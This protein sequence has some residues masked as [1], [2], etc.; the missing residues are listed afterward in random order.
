L[1]EFN[2]A[3]PLLGQTLA[4]WRHRKDQAELNSRLW[5]GVLERDF[6]VQRAKSMSD[7]DGP[8]AISLDVKTDADGNIG[9]NMKELRRRIGAAYTWERLFTLL[10]AV[11]ALERYMLASTTA[12]IESDPLLTPGFPK[13]LDGLLLKKMDLRISQPSLT[14][15]VKGEWAG[16]IA[17]LERL[18]GSVPQQLKDAEGEL[19]KIRK[20]RN[21]IAHSFGSDDGNSLLPPSVSLISGAR[22]D[23]LAQPRQ[24]LSL[25]RLLSWLGLLNDISLAMDEQL[26]AQ[27][28]GDYETAAIYLDWKRAP[29]RY[30]SALGITLTGAKKSREQRFV[31]FLS[32]AFARPIGAD[33]LRTLEDFM[34][35]L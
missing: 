3:L 20:M 8:P 26:T 2:R 28:I 19:E 33:Y 18:F 22:A 35:R 5:V 4:R 11:S 32:L 9:H 15:V 31:N 14:P 13:R 23:R 6:L 29:E 7:S 17:T 34:V 16:R 12:A 21:A 27:Y 10:M 1:A 24:G 25:S 30:E